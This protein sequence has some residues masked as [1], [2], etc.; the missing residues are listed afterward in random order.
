MVS[1]RRKSKSIAAIKNDNGD[2]VYDEDEIKSIAANF[3]KNLFTEENGDYNSIHTDISYP[4][5]SS[6]QLLG[7]NNNI[8]QEEIDQAF[9]SMGAL[10][11]PGPDGLNALFFQSQWGKVGQVS[12]NFIQHLFANPQAVQEINQTFLVLIPKIA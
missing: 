9:M 3:Y 8:K 1:A 5:L 10:K 6:D 7:L 12:S 4:T 11:A 2:W